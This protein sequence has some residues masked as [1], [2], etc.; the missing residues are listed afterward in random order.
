MKQ[1]TVART[2]RRTRLRFTGGSDSY[3]VTDKNKVKRLKD[4]GVYD[5]KTVHSIL[6][7]AFIAHVG[8]VKNGFPLVLPMGY[9]RDGEYLLLHGSITNAMLKNMKVC[10]KYE[11]H[12]ITAAG[13]ELFYNAIEWA[14]FPI[15]G[16][17]HSHDPDCTNEERWSGQCN[18]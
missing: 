14:C 1:D 17:W 2:I 18:F 5:R 8:F 11:V 4:R 13:Q 12:Y 15:K 7:E 6:D 9:A 10:F 3:E 16:A